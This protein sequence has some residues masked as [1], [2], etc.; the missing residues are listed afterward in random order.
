MFS[1]GVGT[2]PCK[3][4]ERTG[5]GKKKKYYA[6]IRQMKLLAPEG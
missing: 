5:H 6:T 3:V 4:M 2:A 1:Y